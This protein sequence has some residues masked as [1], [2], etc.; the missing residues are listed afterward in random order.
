MAEHAA[1][2][3][4]PPRGDHP[5]QEHATIDRAPGSTTAATATQR[6]RRAHI[7]SNASPNSATMRPSPHESHHDH[8]AHALPAPEEL[9][10][11]KLNPTGPSGAL[12]IFADLIF[13]CTGRVPG[14]PGL[15][16]PP[17]DRDRDSTSYT[18]GQRNA[19]TPATYLAHHP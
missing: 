18:Q 10:A 5:T 11:S 16:R 14:Q 8:H 1:P 3:P 19:D 7:P 9:N 13:L 12:P 2:T 4:G 6:A 15:A 17:A